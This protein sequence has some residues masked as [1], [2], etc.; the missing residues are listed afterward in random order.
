LKYCSFDSGNPQISYFFSQLDSDE[1]FSQL[2][3]GIPD[4]YQLALKHEVGDF[5]PIPMSLQKEIRD[6][7]EIKFWPAVLEYLGNIFPKYRTYSFNQVKR[8]GLD[9][10]NYE[11]RITGELAYDLDKVK[12]LLSALPDVSCPK[13]YGKRV[14]GSAI[15]ICKTINKKELADNIY[16]IVEK[17]FTPD[18]HQDPKDSSRY[19]FGL[20]VEPSTGG[21]QCDCCKGE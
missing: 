4:D 18:N 15:R 20:Y 8:Y 1:E 2:S 21:I 5:D 14:V 7:S 11:G 3:S 16:Q 19:R 6:F 10:W 17:C 9:L 12:Y 13:I